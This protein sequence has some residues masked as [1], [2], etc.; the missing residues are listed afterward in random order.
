MRG[1]GLDKGGDAA[2]GD[3]LAEGKCQGAAADFV[4]IVGLGVACFAATV[5][6]VVELFAIGTIKNTGEVF[7][8]GSGIWLGILL[9]KSE[10][11]RV[12]HVHDWHLPGRTSPENR[13]LGTPGP[14]RLIVAKPCPLSGLPKRGCSRGCIER[15]VDR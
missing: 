7:C 12:T 9:E 11:A 13:L 10:I 15:G 1:G 6:H 4:D 14:T 5:D 3:F 8:A 2:S